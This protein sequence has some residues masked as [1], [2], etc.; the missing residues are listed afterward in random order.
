MAIDEAVVV[1]SYRLVWYNAQAVSAAVRAVVVPSYRLVWYNKDVLPSVLG[2]LLFP[3]IAW[4]GIM[5]AG[6]RWTH[7]VLL[8]PVIA[9]YGIIKK[10]I[11]KADG[12][13]CSQ[14]SLGMV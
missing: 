12:S 2:W 4:Y 3:V 7:T 11:L 13:C 10:N 8:F 1:P 6:S 14:L 9:W 5:A